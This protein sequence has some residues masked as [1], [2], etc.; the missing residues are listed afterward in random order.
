MYKTISKKKLFYIIL[1][2]AIVLSGIV[3]KIILWERAPYLSRDSVCY[4]KQSELWSENE[5]DA[6]FVDEGSTPYPPLL[7]FVITKIKFLG[8]TPLCAGIGLNIVMASFLPV[9]TYFIV[10]ALTNNFKA[11]IIGV[12][13]TA[14]HPSINRLSIEIQRDIGYLLFSSLVFLM[15][16]YGKKY[17]RFYHWGIAGLFLSLAFL[18]R[19]EALE[20][21]FILPIPIF[22]L[23]F[24]KEFFSRKLGNLSVFLCSFAFSLLLLSMVIGLRA[25]HFILIFNYFY[26][27]IMV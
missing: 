2:T 17:K 13:L 14:F 24:K 19:I 10:Y 4:L 20:L 9:V 8:W 1:I 7:F 23:D 18:F 16:V 25:K 12:L 22:F 15:I 27:C 21:L 3:S 26:N 6:F 11:S 5:I